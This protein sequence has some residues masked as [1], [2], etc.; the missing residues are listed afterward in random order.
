MYFYNLYAIADSYLCLS[1]SQYL[2]QGCESILALTVYM[3]DYFRAGYA[4]DSLFE[5]INAKSEIRAKAGD[6]EQVSI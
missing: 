1:V 4:A 5:L 6:L 3:N 2:A